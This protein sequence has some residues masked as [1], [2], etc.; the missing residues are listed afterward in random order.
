MSSRLGCHFKEKRPK[1]QPKGSCFGILSVPPGSP[2]LAKENNPEMVLFFCV[3]YITSS[4]QIKLE[5]EQPW[6]DPLNNPVPTVAAESILPD[7]NSFSFLAKGDSSH[8]LQT[9]NW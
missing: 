3:S 1:E 4:Q 8:C 2:G 6:K 7:F 9:K 5:L